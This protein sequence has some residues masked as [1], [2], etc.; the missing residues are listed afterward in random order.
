MTMSYSTRVSLLFGGLLALFVLSGTASIH[1]DWLESALAEKAQPT[2]RIAETVRDLGQ[3]TERK[4]WNVSFS[5]HNV[6]N[7]RLVM[8]ELDLECGCGD[9]IKQTILIPPGETA[10]VTVPLDSR[11]KS[12]KIENSASFLTSD[13]SQPKVTLTAK[14]FVAA[15]IPSQ[16]PDTSHAQQHSILVTE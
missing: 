2:L 12:G 9:K 7:T 4:Q 3:T 14:A 1:R 11:F 16:A 10:E 8:N 15:P 5:I 13:P 6:G